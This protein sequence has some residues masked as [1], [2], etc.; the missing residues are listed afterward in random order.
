M[1]EWVD[2]RMVSG[3]YQQILEAGVAQSAGKQQANCPIYTV[4]PAVMKNK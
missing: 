2:G 4:P 3:K 1:G